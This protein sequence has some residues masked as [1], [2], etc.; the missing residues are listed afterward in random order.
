MNREK[1]DRDPL[2]GLSNDLYLKKTYQNYI[3]TYP[4]SYFVMIDFEKFKSINDTFGH[5]VGDQYLI[6]FAKILQSNFQDSIV[7]RLHGDEFAIL[8]KCSVSELERRFKFCN[9][10]I[11]L[12][13]QERKI[14]KKF[15]FNAGCTKV[16]HGIDNTKEKADYMMYYAKKNHLMFQVF[17]EI[18]WSEK[19]EEK[20]F[21]NSIQMG[22]NN[23][24]FSYSTREF[25]DKNCQKKDISQICTKWENGTSIFQNGNYRLL[26]EYSI[27]T[28][29]DLHNIQYLL[30]RCH[31]NEQ[32]MISI[33][34]QT[35]LKV[36]SLVDYFRLSSE[37][38]SIDFSK[39]IFS[40]NLQGI[41]PEEN[42]LIIKKIELFKNMGFQ[43]C[44][45]QY[46]SLL[47]DEI[48]EYSD[49]DYVKFQNQYWKGAM[50][51]S[52]TDYWL[53]K[54]VDM[55]IGCQEKCIPVFTFIENEAEAQYLSSFVTEESLL[56]GNFYSKEKRLVL[57]K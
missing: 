48:W 2:T 5:H 49:I 35:L 19:E 43:V 30:E 50:N 21:L 25:F 51:H 33:D 55:F 36:D 3:T 22:L 4:D 29:L 17:S 47:G 52:K 32:M 20:K 42:H 41:R 15:G 44:L 26:R 14:P 11:E 34:Y 57:K 10:K 24:E 12:A 9:K 8:T 56:S 7:V 27:L 53:R 31:F 37:L 38:F 1:I 28:Q 40:I 39:I 13:V 16:E 46:S 6:L 45:D 18:I 54:K 23:N